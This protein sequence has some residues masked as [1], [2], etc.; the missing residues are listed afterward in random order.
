MV[1]HFVVAIV[2]SKQT[3]PPRQEVQDLIEQVRHPRLTT[4]S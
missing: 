1:I 3:A 2:V 4:G